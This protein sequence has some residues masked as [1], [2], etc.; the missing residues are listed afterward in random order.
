MRPRQEP[1]EAE[2]E[3]FLPC[4]LGATNVNYQ[5]TREVSGPYSLQ[6][7]ERWLPDGHSS[8]GFWIA[9]MDLC[10][11]VV[12]LDTGRAALCDPVNDRLIGLA[13]MIAL[14]GIIHGEGI[15]DAINRTAAATAKIIQSAN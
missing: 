2:I 5:L 12:Q 3:A 6:L 13:D 4:R 9:N 15:E 11:F 8:S 14:A 1:L 7:C 10:N